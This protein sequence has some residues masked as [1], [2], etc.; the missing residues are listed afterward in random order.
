MSNSIEK[1]QITVF[2]CSVLIVFYVLVSGFAGTQQSDLSIESRISKLETSQA[3]VMHHIE[4]L[5]AAATANMAHSQ[6]GFE[7][8]AALEREVSLG[9]QI[10]M[11]TLCGVFMLMLETLARLVKMRGEK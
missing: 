10:G 9:R 2:L 1:T 5:G 7:R 8:L 4:L 3:D 11:G 6:V